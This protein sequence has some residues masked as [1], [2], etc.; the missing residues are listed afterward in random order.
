MKAAQHSVQRIGGY[1]MAFRTSFNPPTANAN[2]WVA[3]A[4]NKYESKSLAL[5]ILSII[6][7]SCGKVENI[8]LSPTV[9]K[10]SSPIISITQTVSPT[11]EGVPT[12]TPFPTT[13]ADATAQAF[14]SVLCNST[15]ISW[16]D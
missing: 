10:Q 9:T 11:A 5:I 7:I 1:G 12:R 6:L 13:S 4:M 16:W 2:R 15:V 8:Q 3:I 14:D